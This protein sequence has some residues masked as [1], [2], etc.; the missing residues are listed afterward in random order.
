M[1]NPRSLEVD[2][3]DSYERIASEFA[4]T[5]QYQWSWVSKFIKSLP[6]NSMICDV[7]CGAGQNMNVP[8]YRFIG[9]DNCHSFLRICRESN[10]S[11]LYGDMCSI[12]LIDGYADHVLC[13]AAFHH[14]KTTEERLKAL[15]EMKRIKQATGYIL[16]SVWSIKQPEKTKRKFYSYGD[17]VV[18]FKKKS[19]ELVDRY[20]H[21]FDPDFLVSM[22]LTCK[23]R[24]IR[25]FWDCGNEVYVLT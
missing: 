16:L 25:H 18:S 4:L 13:I 20:Y 5:R 12:P 21:I 22:F 19:G 11:A 1:N 15:L 14:L 6:K 9:I 7:G 10:K 24:L 17:T 3:Q 8:E 23:L 2:V